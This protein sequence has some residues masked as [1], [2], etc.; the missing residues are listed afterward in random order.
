M[1]LDAIRA[2][3]ADLVLGETCVGCDRP[4][5]AWCSQCAQA[6][7]GLP[8]RT[9]PDPCPP[10]LPPVWTV[11]AYDGVV[12]SALVAHK[13]GARLALTRPLGEALA[14][15]VLGLLATLEAETGPVSLVPVPSRRA[16]VRERGHDPLPRMARAAARSLR[17]AGI[18][19]AVVSALR[20]NRRVADQAGLGAAARAANLA[21]AFTASARRTAGSGGWV[22]V[23]D[24]VTTGSTI[25]EAAAALASVGRPVLG[26]AVVAATRRDSPSRTVSVRSI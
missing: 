10:G 16:V 8:H 25:G 22:V 1:D 3:G 9:R 21:G 17:R 19:A 2:A 23:D 15:A 20:P 6:L 14:L 18:A 26:A 11:A 7:S 4:G 5:L 12:R 24:I 13:E